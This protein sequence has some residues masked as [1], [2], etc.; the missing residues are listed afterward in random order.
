MKSL[1]LF[2]RLKQKI[3]YE[4]FIKQNPTAYIY[5][6]FAMLS[7]EEKEG[8]KIQ[9]DFLVEKGNR[10]A[11]AEYPFEEIKVS[12]QEI[13]PK[14]KELNFNEISLDI[15]EINEEVKKIQERNNDKT[16]INKIIAILKENVWDL[17]CLT[18]TVDILKIKI[19]AKTKECLLFKKE[20]L[21]SFIQLKKTKK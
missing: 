10:V 8:D 21:M 5:A 19:D 13:N 20:S 7:S 3:C 11:I 18:S 1:Q 16:K 15:E 9:F 12:L 2:D 6:I 14:P 17:N 4:K